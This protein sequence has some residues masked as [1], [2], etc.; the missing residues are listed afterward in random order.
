MNRKYEIQ[1]IATENYSAVARTYAQVFAGEPWREVSRCTNCGNFSQE[2]PQSGASCA[3]GG[4]FSEEAYPLVETTNYVGRE[5]VKP[6][7]T[8]L[9]LTQAALFNQV[10]QIAQGFGWGFKMSPAELSQKYRT[11]EMQSVVT[12]LL[13]RAGFFYYVSEVGVLPEVQGLG[14][15]KR[16]TNQVVDAGRRKGYDQFVVR[17]NEDSAMRYILEKMGMQAIV[18]LQTGVKDT[19]NESRVLFINKR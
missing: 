8:G 10:Q 6:D 16:L 2:K 7:A 5:L 1:P 12:D 15:G 19:E 17:T 18:G 3:C 13:V 14:F 4:A 9:F 11:E